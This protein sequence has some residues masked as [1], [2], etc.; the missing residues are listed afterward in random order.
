MLC[1]GVGGVLRRNQQRAYCST[2]ASGNRRIA[3]DSD[4][5]SVV[6]TRREQENTPQ[7]VC[8]ILGSHA[9]GRVL[10]HTIPR[11]VPD[12][13]QQIGLLSFSMFGNLGRYATYDDITKF[14]IPRPQGE[15]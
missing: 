6:A 12:D 13:P 8:F 2:I 15:P 7:T 3:G 14:E 11:D 5:W 10:P 4:V 9:M 1:G